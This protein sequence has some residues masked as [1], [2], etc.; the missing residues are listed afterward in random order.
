[1]AADGVSAAILPGVDRTDLQESFFIDTLL[2]DMASGNG[3]Q[4]PGGPGRP[5]MSRST[6]TLTSRG[7]SVRHRRK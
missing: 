7:S 1:M 2:P 6:Y 5:T 4:C 3:Q